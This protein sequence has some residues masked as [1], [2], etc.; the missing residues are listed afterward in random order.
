MKT[1]PE[2]LYEIIRNSNS[3]N[4]KFEGIRF[5]SDP[6]NASSHPASGNKGIHSRN[7]KSIELGKET[8]DINLKT[9]S[10]QSRVI[11]KKNKGNIKSTNFSVSTQE[12]D[13][14]KASK[15]CP[16]RIVKIQRLRNSLSK[17]K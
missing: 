9:I 8:K 10:T 14:K 3:F 6:F 16:S 11:R 4:K 7:A 13:Q 2:L 17:R 12:V 1:S 15:G 5:T